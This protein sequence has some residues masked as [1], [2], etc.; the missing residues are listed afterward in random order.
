M[1]RVL[2]CAYRARTVTILA[3]LTAGLLLL[4]IAALLWDAMDQGRGFFWLR[5]LFN[6]GNDGLIGRM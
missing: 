5:S 4:I 2:L 3:G 1:G 6:R